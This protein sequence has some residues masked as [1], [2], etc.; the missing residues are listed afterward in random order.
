MG[1]PSLLVSL[2]ML[3]SSLLLPCSGNKDRLTVGKTISGNQTIISA[4]E[5]FA[6]GFFSPGNST[7][8]Y[9]GIWYNNIPVKTVVWVANREA[10][11]SLPEDSSGVF[12]ISDNG[13]LVVLDGNGR[14]VWSSNVS[15]ADMDKKNTFGL[16]MDSSNLVLR[17]SSDQSDLWR[18][19]DYPSDTALPGMKLSSN[20]K[21]GQSIHLT[22]WKNEVDPAPGEFLLEVNR[23]MAI[24]RGPNL[25]ARTDW[26][27]NPSIGSLLKVGNYA[28]YLTV[29][30]NDEGVNVTFTLSQ[31]S[32]FSRFVLN[33]NGR[34]E[35]MSWFNKEWMTLWSAPEKECDFYGRCGPNAS[36]YQNSSSSICKCLDGFK[37]KV[38]SEW[39]IGNWSGGCIRRKELSCS[40]N[41]FLRVDVMKL[42]YAYHLITIRNS[43]VTECETECKRNCSCTDYAFRKYENGAASR[44][45]NWFGDFDDL[46]QDDI[47]GK[48]FYVRLDG[49]ELVGTP[50]A[51]NFMDKNRVRVIISISAA[52][53][54]LLLIGAF[55]YSLRRRL[56]EHAVGGSDTSVVEIIYK[57]SEVL[58]S[59]TNSPELSSF[60]L[61]TLRVLTD[62]FSV[63]NKLGEGGFGPVYKG[64]LLDGQ[65][66]AI[67]RLSEKSEQGFEEFMNGLKLIA[68]LQHR[69]LVR[70]VGFCIEEKEK[71]LIYEYMPNKSLDKFL[72]GPT[73]D[74]ELDWNTRF[75][76]IEGIAQG[77]LYLHEHSRLK[78]IHRDLKAS[79]IL[80]DG[81]MKP[82]IS[83]F[84]TARIFG[85]NQTEANTCRLVGTL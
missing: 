75:D 1:W 55:V 72:F 69:N 57:E 82:K 83:D 81:D 80:L 64:S 60:S 21:T 84:A 35:L 43:S 49:S 12:T 54:A 70:L 44:C 38:D 7:N 73:K 20:V 71:I 45:L 85:I 8:R 14:I 65:E 31:L 63:T 37:P 9:L 48:D 59:E 10:P 17:Q 27:G 2:F 30:I 28:F 76:I 46:V 74:S 25:F 11:L 39:D 36:C 5:T 6:L 32:V 78:V 19:F 66:V 15:A 56:T 53:S 47:N 68:K 79:N 23:G 18:S 3:W 22:S 4:G 33:Q 24:R 62:N 42:P 52:S 67:K 16:L 50:E 40:S 51:N 13:N 26:D 34:V 61:S 29:T 58:A 41:G 77:L